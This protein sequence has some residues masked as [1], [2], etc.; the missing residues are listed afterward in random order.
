M[1]DTILSEP[2]TCPRPKRAMK[3]LRLYALESLGREPVRGSEEGNSLQCQETSEQ[4]C[5]LFRH[6]SARPEDPRFAEHSRV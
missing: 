3:E 4:R 1:Q 2:G 5:Y 6:P